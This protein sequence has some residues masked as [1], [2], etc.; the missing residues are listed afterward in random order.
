MDDDPAADDGGDGGSFRR[1]LKRNQ[2][3]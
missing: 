2:N 3:A 1:E